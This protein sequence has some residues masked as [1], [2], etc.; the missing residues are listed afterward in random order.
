MLSIPWKETRK[1]QSNQSPSKAT[2]A[3]P[4]DKRF[5]SKENALYPPN[6]SDA[7]PSTTSPHSLARPPPPASAE[8]PKRKSST[9]LLPIHHP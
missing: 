3:F 1:H 6:H 5:K 7:I 2:Y 9:P 4:K 8:A